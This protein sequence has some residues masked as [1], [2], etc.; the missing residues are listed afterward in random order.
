MNGFAASI[1]PV[2][3]ADFVGLAFADLDMPRAIAAMAHAARGHQW[4]YAVTPNACLLARYAADPMV[5]M[6]YQKAHLCFLDSRVIALAARL[7]GLRPPPVIPGSDLVA[8]L[9][10]KAIMPDTPVCIVGGSKAAI[11]RLAETF[12]LRR[13][14]HI[15]PSNGFWR[16]PEEVEETAAFIAAAAADYTFLVVGSPGQD[17]LANR[18][19]VMPGARGIGICAGAS[20][21]FLTGEQKRAPR[22]LQ[23]LALEWA[24]R[25]ARQPRRLAYRYMVESPQALWLVWRHA[26][27]QHGLVRQ[28][29]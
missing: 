6:L 5:H 14:H 1:M 25:L 28:A 27:R 21:D 18:L 4:R 8:G 9:F 3:K 19:A 16:R 20:I 10:R 29:K 15:N 26:L 17:I 22:L 13:L 11:A 24:Y 23:V 7:A 2:A 12:R